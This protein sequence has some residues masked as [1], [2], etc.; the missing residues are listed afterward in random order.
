MVSFIIKFALL[1]FIPSFFLTAFIRTQFFGKHKRKSSP[2]R[3][4]L[5]LIL[6]AYLAS[7]LFFLLVPNS[8][9]M[10]QGIHLTGLETGPLLKVSGGH[11]FRPFKTIQS[12]LRHVSGLHLVTNLLGN[13]LIFSPLGFLLPLLWKKMDQ[14]LR[15]FRIFLVSSC[16]I[17]IAQ[18]FIG[19]SSDI[20]D[21]ILNV[22]GGLLGFC[23]YRFLAPLFSLK[24]FQR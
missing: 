6:V 18:S 17:E 23:L 22:L 12:Y 14:P 20:D 2:K 9:L 13:I 8:V 4:Y 10:G 21:I 3:E 11:N 24:K 15:L 7:L 16:L 5:F 1:I 19:R